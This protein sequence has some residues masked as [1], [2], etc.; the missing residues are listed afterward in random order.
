MKKFG[1]NSDQFRLEDPEDRSTPVQRFQAMIAI[2]RFDHLGLP[3]LEDGPDFSD[4]RELFELARFR[5]FYGK[6]STWTISAAEKNKRASSFF[7]Y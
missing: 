5:N 1:R 7:G 6:F 2:W 4:E 3:R